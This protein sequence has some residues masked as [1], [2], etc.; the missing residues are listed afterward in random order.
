MPAI[1]SLSRTQAGI[2]ASGP[3]GLVRCR[4][5]MTEPILQPQE[6]LYC[7]ASADELILVG[8]LPHGIAFSADGG[9]Q[10]QS[11]Y[12][13][14]VAEAVLCIAPDPCYLES[15]VMLAGTAGGGIL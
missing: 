12:V 2:W 5:G 13:D 14:A 11:A 8:G 10:W 1:L 4:D 6:Q 3:E 7:S 9:T 15:G